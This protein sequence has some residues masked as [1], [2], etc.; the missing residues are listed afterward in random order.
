MSA[1][2]SLGAELDFVLQFA[3]YQSLPEFLEFVVQV[4]NHHT[5]R[6]I[7]A[8]KFYQPAQDQELA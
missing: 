8:F 1:R 7:V 5:N 6:R 4:V 2:Q 3:L